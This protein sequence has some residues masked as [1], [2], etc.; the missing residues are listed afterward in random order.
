MNNDDVLATFDTQMRRNARPDSP[1][2][3]VDR[4]ETTTRQTGGESGWN[5]V[6]WSALDA[7]SADAAI[8]E[9]VEHFAGLGLEFEWKLYSHD[10]PH[11]LPERLLAAGFTA[12][13]QEAVMVAE[14][15]EL[16]T[17]VAPPEGITLREVTDEA[18]VDLMAIVHDQAFDTDGSRIRRQLLE[19]LT[20]APDTVV[21]VVAMAGDVPV[22]SARSEFIPGTDFAGLWGGGTVEAWRGRGI[23]RALI[24]YRA[25]IA[26]ERGYRYLQVDASDQSAPILARLGFAQLSTTTPYVYQPKS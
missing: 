16:S 4:T 17:A 11:D 19:Q 26:L 25:R 23:Y 7:E 12:E 3:R 21:A 13:P 2:A 18:G 14:A 15:G 5:G 22:S 20:E 24:A 1:G 9:Q 10:L 6:L 8:A